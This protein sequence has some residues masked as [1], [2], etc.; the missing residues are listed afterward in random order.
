MLLDIIKKG[1]DLA[2]ETTKI[3][4]KALDKT[5]ETISEIFKSE[6]EYEYRT[7]GTVIKNYYFKCSICRA[8]FGK[9]SRKEDAKLVLQK[10][11]NCKRWVCKN[12]W[13]YEVGECKSCS[14]VV[15]PEV[16]IEKS[17]KTGLREKV[18]YI[19]A[20][21]RER[22]GSIPTKKYKP[23]AEKEFVIQCLYC[24]QW[25]C[26]NCWNF[27]DRGCKICKPFIAPETRVEKKGLKSNT[28]FICSLCRKEYGPIKTEEWK[29]L[30]STGFKGVSVLGSALTYTGAGAV[31]GIP[32]SIG[33]R[34]ASA[35]IEHGGKKSIKTDRKV[36]EKSIDLSK[37]FLGRCPKCKRWVCIEC[38][39]KESGICRSC[40]GTYRFTVVI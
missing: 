1:I 36:K 34:G 37:K 5:I 35:S 31:V 19:C 7:V 27:E 9:F 40:N 14:P 26:G 39:D 12:C 18:T 33:A 32:I 38:W 10:C 4:K 13:N 3:P 25:V 24:K 20:I 15:N 22:A 30:A 8:E 17:I 11:N 16:I 2:K 29:K 28:Y 23:G 21:C 6:E